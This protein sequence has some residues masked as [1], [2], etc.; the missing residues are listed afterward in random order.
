[1][2]DFDIPRRKTIAAGQL[3]IDG[4]CR[5]AAS[6]E[7]TT[8]SDPTTEEV[9]TTVA[10]ASAA[11]AGEA[12]AAAQRAFENGPWGRMHLEERAKVLFRV[13]D[14]L[15][16]RADDFAVREAMDMG[17]PYHDFRDTIML[18]LD[19]LRPAAR[20]PARCPQSRTGHLYLIRGAP[21]SL[22]CPYK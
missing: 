7:T 18:G 22:R 21:I 4:Q 2:A 10:K 13:A 19:A 17:M 14:L 15:D 8:T 11:E 5:D 16:E 9:I 20:G 6:G 3:L 12:V 1:M